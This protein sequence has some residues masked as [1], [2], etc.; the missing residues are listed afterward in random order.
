MVAKN[1]NSKL[2]LVQTLTVC[3]NFKYLKKKKKLNFYFS[4]VKRFKGNKYIC[5][6]NSFDYFN[7]KLIF[8]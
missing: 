3:S 8:F 6:S 7:E 5:H 1:C 2:K 4:S